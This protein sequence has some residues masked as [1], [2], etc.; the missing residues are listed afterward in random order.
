MKNDIKFKKLSLKIRYLN[1]EL[2]EVKSLLETYS[3]D[4]AKYIYTL[5][6]EHD[7]EILPV[8][9]KKVQKK[10]NCKLEDEVRVDPK[11]DR[12]QNEIFKDLYRQ[13]ARVSHPD[14]TDKDRDKARLFRQ[15]TD[16]KNSDDLITLLDICDDLEIDTPSL[17]DDHIKIIEKNIKK[18]EEEINRLKKADA[19]VWGTADEKGRSIL[20]G[21]IIQKYKLNKS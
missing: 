9:N 19:W 15:A 12:K 21:K 2:E 16:A 11:R 13:V 10:E 6:R 1:L 5:Q 3:S 14:K 20:E 4:F 18:K 17:D 8:N 7:I